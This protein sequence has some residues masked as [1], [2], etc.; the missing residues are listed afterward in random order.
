MICFGP[1]VFS[2]PFSNF[3]SKKSDCF[4]FVR[5]AFVPVALF[6]GS[7]FLDGSFLADEDG[8]G[9]DELTEAFPV[10]TADHALDGDAG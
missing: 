9:E 1:F 6:V 4:R 10:D 3:L 7:L 5:G 2:F 8:E